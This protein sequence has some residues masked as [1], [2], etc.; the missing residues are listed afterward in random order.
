MS[1]RELDQRRFS[2]ITFEDEFIVSL[3]IFR[4]ALP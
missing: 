2:T 3:D 4:I 1:R